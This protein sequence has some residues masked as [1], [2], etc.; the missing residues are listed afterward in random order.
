MNITDWTFINYDFK[1]IKIKSKL[2][3]EIKVHRLQFLLFTSQNFA[4]N[5]KQKQR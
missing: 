3:Y 4:L 5:S 1:T 2:K